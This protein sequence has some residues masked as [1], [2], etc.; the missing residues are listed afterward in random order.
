VTDQQHIV[1]FTPSGRRGNFKAGTTVLH[2]AR[3][4][5]VDLDS[6]CGGR[7]ICGRCQ[8]AS[9]SEKLS[10][11]TTTER[12]YAKRKGLTPG[13]RLG[14]AATIQGDTIIDVPPESQVHRPVVRKSL[15]ERPV[16]IDPIVRLCYLEMPEGD[17]GDAT[18]EA[19]RVSNLLASDWKT[20]SSSW[21][22][23]ALQKLQ[24]A[25]A[26]G[27]RKI[28]VAVHGAVHD[29][30]TDTSS[31]GRIIAVWPGFHDQAL[32]LAVDIGSTTLAL[33]LCDL[34]DGRIV[35]SA[36][37]MNPQIRFG[38]DVMSRVSYAMMHSDG[39]DAMTQAIRTELDRLTGDVLADIDA[40]RNDILDIV[41]VGNPV[42]HHLLLGLDP[43]PL[44]AAPFAL[45]TDEAVNLSAADL[46]LNLNSG[47]RG[48]VLPCIAGHVGADTAAVILAEQPH[49][50]DEPVLIIDIGTN[51]EIVLG[52]RHR[53][54]AASSP[55]GPAFEGAQI[56]AGQRA[57]PG[58]IE[59]V[60]IDPE[61]LEPKVKVIGCDL[62]SDDPAFDEQVTGLC[63]SG[64]IEAIG[65]MVLT[66][67]VT[68]DG[69]I[70]GDMAARTN[71]IQSSDRTFSFTLWDGATK[72]LVTQDDIRA[73][74]L[75]KGALTAGW[76]LLMDISG[77]Q[78]V[79]RTILSGAFGAHIDPL[80]AMI[81]GMVPDGPVENVTAA[82]NAAGTG[83]RLALVNAAARREIEETV[84][85]VE[86][87]ETATEPKF[88]E[89]FVDAMAFP[90][91][92]D[93]Y[94]HLRTL[95]DLPEAVVETRKRRRRR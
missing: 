16:S 61:T 10:G 13:R 73:I 21:D 31:Q 90:N 77:L 89:H 23:A 87:I 11:L 66:R 48:Y 18:S 82:G 41:L 7:G 59:R 15:E 92:A 37:A 64:I 32:G 47:T 70:D 71:R 54:L 5:G 78:T 95:V 85:N 60:R 36:G 68:A 84:R 8:I 39:G 24:A 83:A 65:E 53:L 57:A 34:S 22:L 9:E 40:T 79:S 27:D 42:M 26:S 50:S 94:T 2:A 38:E 67:L 51:A 4:L 25:L 33:Y 56:S 63:G 52:D 46:D 93:P 86:K 30:E 58:A 74:Q 80:Y 43:A 3:Q 35:A 6:I 12:E 62:W 20:E 28:T 19:T 72:I 1:V 14:C 55:T 91:K 76:R 17:L 49:K 88:Q 75:A 29:I 69:I 45:A 44:G 81:L